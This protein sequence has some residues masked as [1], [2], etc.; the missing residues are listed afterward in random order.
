MEKELLAIVFSC[1]KFHQYIYGKKV[2]VH[3]D[4]KPLEDIC[5]KNI[6]RAPKRLQRMLMCLLHYDVEVIYKKGTEMYISDHL[7]R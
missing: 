6:N 1:N 3:S 7:S 2:T 4:H 5:K